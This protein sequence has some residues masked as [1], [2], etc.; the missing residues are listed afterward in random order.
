LKQST[1]RQMPFMLPKKV[2]ELNASN[3]WKFAVIVIAALA[4]QT[5]L[6]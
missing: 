4:W 3:A 5:I 1:V 6:P 2:S